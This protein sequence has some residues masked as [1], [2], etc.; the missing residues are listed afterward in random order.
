MTN[1]IPTFIKWAGGKSQL[2]RDIENQLK[3]LKDFNIGTYYEPFLGSGAV[4]FYLKSTCLLNIKNFF[5]SD[6]NKELIECFIVVRDDV[7][8]LI[9]ELRKLKNEYKT[10]KSEKEKEEY[11]Y[12][13]RDSYN[14][15]KKTKKN[16]LKIKKAALLIFL[17]KTCFNGLYRVNADNEFNVPFGKYENPEIFN[18]DVLRKA[19]K[20]LKGTIIKS[21]D[22][23]KILKSM[24]PRDLV[25]FDPPYVPLSKTSSFT[26]Y[27]K[28]D[29]NDNDQ[30][31]LARVF[32]KLNK[33]GCYLL[34]SNSDTDK[35]KKLYASFKPF[36]VVK[37]RRSI[38]CI[39]TKRGKINE[40]LIKNYTTNLKNFIK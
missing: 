12:Y 16:S 31:N 7:E 18:E 38:S 13:R 28:V 29:F 17:N 40:L 21:I 6:S 15:I 32:K 24:K 33:L 9:L 5:L 36:K 22:F 4:F 2:I 35:I 3:K 26:S 11:Y 8:K 37:A 20:L 30:E 39:G 27:T 14:E 23:R 19:N 1:G 25:Y 34:L 10:L